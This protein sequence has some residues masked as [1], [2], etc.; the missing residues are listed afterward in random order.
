MEIS[1][2][3]P[4]TADDPNLNC[5]VEQGIAGGTKRAFLILVFCPGGINAGK[6]TGFAKNAKTV[7]T[8]KGTQCCAV[9]CW[10]LTVLPPK[11]RFHFVETSPVTH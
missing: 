11:S 2:P 10:I 8:G 6:L 7:S 3:M 9:K 4:A 5:F 1:D